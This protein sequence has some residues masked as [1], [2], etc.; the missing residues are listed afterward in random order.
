MSPL[1]CRMMYV[2]SS[3]LFWP[4]SQLLF[5]PHS[6]QI[7]FIPLCFW[8]FSPLS[9]S[10]KFP[11]DY[12]LYKAQVSSILIHAWVTPTPLPVLVSLPT[13]LSYKGQIRPDKDPLKQDE[14]WGCGEGSIPSSLLPCS[15]LM[16]KD[17]RVIFRES[18][19]SLVRHTRMAAS[20]THECTS[21]LSSVIFC[22]AAL[23]D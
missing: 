17:E 22:K 9:V 14:G 10:S 11:P 20:G 3:S 21:Y 19:G 18:W 8:A 6:D 23:H 13:L 2:R 1:R 5:Q 4:K 16:A 7:H 12:T 15:S